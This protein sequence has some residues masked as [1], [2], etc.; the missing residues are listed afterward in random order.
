MNIKTVKKFTT[1]NNNTYLV[2]TDV[3]DDEFTVADK[4]DGNKEYQAILQW[5]ADGNTIQESD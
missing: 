1:P 5:V 2:I 4:S 3:H